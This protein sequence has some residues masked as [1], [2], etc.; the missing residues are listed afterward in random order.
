MPQS[1]PV[2]LLVS[3]GCCQSKLLGALSED[4]LKLFWLSLPQLIFTSNLTILVKTHKRGSR[5]W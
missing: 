3:P 5:S 2:V 1:L 4:A